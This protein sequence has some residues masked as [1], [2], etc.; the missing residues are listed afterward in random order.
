[1]ILVNEKLLKKQKLWSHFGQ[2][3]G[4][5]SGRPSQTF[6]GW[7]LGQNKDG[8]FVFLWSKTST[9]AG[10]KVAARKGA[11]SCVLRFLVFAFSCVFSLSR[12][13]DS[14]LQNK[15]KCVMYC[16]IHQYLM[17]GDVFMRF[18]AFLCVFVHFYAFLCVLVRFYAFVHFGL[19]LLSSVMYSGFM[20]ALWQRGQTK[21]LIE[22][23]I[24][25]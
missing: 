12:F 10:Q 7:W 14:T 20:S 11:F 1:M 9:I 16:K 21:C 3:L 24:F 15:V 25:M 18:Y 13:W 2:F 4:N 19:G 6:C 22:E 8:S 17:M 23:Q 5:Q